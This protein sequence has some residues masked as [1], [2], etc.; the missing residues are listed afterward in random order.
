[1]IRSV[2]RFQIRSAPL[3]VT[4][5]YGIRSLLQ[6][7]S[8]ACLR[9][10]LSLLLLSLSALVATMMNGLPLDFNHPVI[11]WSNSVGSRLE[12]VMTTDSTRLGLTARYFSIIG[13]HSL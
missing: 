12:S 7:T 10:S 8:D 1:M 2:N 5:E 11:S 13:P 4:D 9:F 3:R 6:N